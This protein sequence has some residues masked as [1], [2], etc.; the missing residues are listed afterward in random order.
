MAVW[1]DVYALKFTTIGLS[2]EWSNVLSSQFST[3]S[4]EVD[5]SVDDLAATARLPGV[6]ID[7]IDYLIYSVDG[8]NIVFPG[9]DNVVITML[10][11]GTT[12]GLVFWGG[13]EQTVKS[14]TDT[15][16]TVGPIDGTGLTIGQS[17]DWEVWRPGG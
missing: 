9:Q 6:S 3:L 14:W 10:A 13:V 8:D 17:Y 2:G 11:A 12:E 16:I 7:V 15:A 1:S 4:N 5:L